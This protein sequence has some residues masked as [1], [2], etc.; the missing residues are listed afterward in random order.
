MRIEKNN[1]GIRFTLSKTVGIANIG[2]LFELLNQ[3]RA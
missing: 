3:G 2:L 1:N